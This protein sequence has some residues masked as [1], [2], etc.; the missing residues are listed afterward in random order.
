MDI[1]K[2]ASDWAK[3]EVFSTTFFIIAGVLFVAASVGFWHLGKTDL[4]R[5]YIIPTLVAGIML[6]I[7]GFG[8]FF[9]NKA[10]V[11]NFPGAYKQD[12]VAFVEAENAR[13][14]RTLKEYSLQVFK[15]IPVLIIAAAL[16]IIFTGNPVWRAISITTIAML[17]VILLIDG[18]A[19]A[20][21]MAYKEQLELVEK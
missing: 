3:A 12:V 1:L 21:I 6:L 8:L 5:A 10:R 13:V 20:R 18:T 19:H 11:A 9:S 4:A 17:I 7:I 14:D 16:V 2:A 15:I